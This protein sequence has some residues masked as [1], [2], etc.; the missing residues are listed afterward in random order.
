[1]ERCKQY[2]LLLLAGGKSSRM[3]R[4][5]PELPYQGK[6]FLEHM[7]CKARQ[8]G[9]DTCYISGWASPQ[10][11][12]QT[13]WDIY[14]DRGPLGGLHACMEV[15]NTPYCLVLP[16]DAPTLPVSIL[17]SLLT[18]HERSPDPERV[19]IWEH[20]DR[21]EPLIAVY[22]RSMAPRIAALIR[23]D[24][25]PVFRAIS[26]WGYDRFRLELK[27]AQPVNINTPELYETLL[28]Q[29]AHS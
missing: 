25:A 24:S 9:I 16:V 6:T 27:Q 2:S 4:P 3:G 21:Q 29:N 8:L 20:G 11:D 23:K 26:Q 18:A 17:E 14:P 15:M 10:Q 5:K 1:M 19:L 13:V 22:P 28:Q 7:L 12:V